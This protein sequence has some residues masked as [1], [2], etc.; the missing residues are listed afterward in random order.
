MVVDQLTS[1]YMMMR[2]NAVEK[3]DTKNRSVKPP[4]NNGFK[5]FMKLQFSFIYVI[6]FSLEFL[7]RN[8]TVTRVI[9]SN[10][11]IPTV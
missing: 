3:P 4:E 2:S 6:A 10:S 1:H 11:R 9:Y 7:F 8:E 5:L